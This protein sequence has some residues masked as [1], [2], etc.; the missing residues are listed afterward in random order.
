MTRGLERDAVL[1]YVWM[2]CGS[3]S[4]SIMATLSHALREY[5]DWQFIALSRAFLAFVLAV[6]LGMTARVKFAIFQ[7]RTLWIRSLSGSLSLVCGFYSLTHLPAPEALTLTHIF[8]VW[9]A[10]LSW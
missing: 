3:V 6:S 9:V 4:F 8:P 10:L 2:V 7:P 5:Y 1:P